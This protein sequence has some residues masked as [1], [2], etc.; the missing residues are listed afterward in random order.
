[1]NNLFALSLIKL[2]KWLWSKRLIFTNLFYT[3]FG[4]ILEAQLRVYD[5]WKN[6]SSSNDIMRLLIKIHVDIFHRSPQ[7]SIISKSF[8]MNDTHIQNESDDV[9]G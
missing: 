8:S 2:Y 7:G 4:S 1:M 3:C 9:L 5:P 6:F